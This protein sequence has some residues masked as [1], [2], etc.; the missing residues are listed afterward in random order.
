MAKSEPFP[1]EEVDVEGLDGARGRAVGGEHAQRAQAVERGREGGFA[2]GVVDDVAERAVGDLLHARCEI[3]APVVDAVVGPV[4]PGEFALLGR[5]RRPDDGGAERVAPLAQEQPDAARGGM[6]QDR[7]A[8]LHR[9]GLA[10]QVLRRETLEHHDGADLVGDGLRQ[11]DQQPGRHVALLGIGAERRAVGHA[12]AGRELGHVGADRDD[13]AGRLVA[14]DQRQGVRVD[15]LALVDVDEVEPHGALPYAD[16]SGAGWRE[17]DV[18]DRQDVGS[19]EGVNAD[20]LGHESLRCR[21]PHHRNPGAH[22]ATG[23]AQTARPEPGFRP[24]AGRRGGS[25][26]SAPGAAPGACRPPPR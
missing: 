15:A 13:V 16:L 11:V 3:L 20:R 24:G 6:D 10:Q 22:P 8:R 1:G 19:P 17:G 26:G 2:D 9:V 14:E 18:L 7:V 4:L 12:V 5:A 23:P 25:P 21:C